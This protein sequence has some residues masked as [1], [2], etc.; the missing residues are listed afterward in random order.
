MEDSRTQGTANIPFR[1]F[2][3]VHEPDF[4]WDVTIRSKIHGLDKFVSGP[5]PEING[6]S[7]KSCTVINDISEQNRNFIHA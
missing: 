6:T 2:R 1:G 3:V 5:V 4:E 7:I